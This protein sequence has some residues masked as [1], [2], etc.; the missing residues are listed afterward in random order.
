[1][2][3]L[4]RDDQVVMLAG[5]D[6]G[7][8]GRILKVDNKHGQFLVQGINMKFKHMRRSQE[9][10]EGGRSRREYPVD[11]SNVAFHDAESGKG[12]R[13]G[14]EIVDGKKIRVMRPSGKP[15]DH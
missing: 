7:K 5:A 2:T 12:V 3:R 13:L 14:A 10:P 9:M 6:R 8:T 4:R 1:M 15:V 11:M